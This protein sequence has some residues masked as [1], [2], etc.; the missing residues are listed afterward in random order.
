[1]CVEK[2]HQQGGAG[3]G[4]QERAGL[5]LRFPAEHRKQGVPPRKGPEAWEFVKTDD[6]ALHQHQPQ[7]HGTSATSRK[8]SLRKR[9]G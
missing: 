8:F 2:R 5:S 4:G 6:S 3:L 7:L 9:L 1:M